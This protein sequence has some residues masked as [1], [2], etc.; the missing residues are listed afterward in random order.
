LSNII[1]VPMSVTAL[2]PRETFKCRQN[3]TLSA[4]L[5]N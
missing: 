2:N 1:S 3:S 5:V 4:R